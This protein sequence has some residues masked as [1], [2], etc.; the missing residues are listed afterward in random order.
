MALLSI[1]QFLIPFIYAFI[2]G[3]LWHKGQQGWAI[4][5]TV[6][7]IL[8]TIAGLRERINDRFNDVIAEIKRTR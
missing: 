1:I 6:F 2:V 5:F 4:G 7:I 8:D 3:W